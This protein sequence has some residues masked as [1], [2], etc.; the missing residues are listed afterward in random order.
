MPVT[1]SWDCSIVRVLGLWLDEETVAPG[2]GGP[3]RKAEET[4]SGQTAAEERGALTELA[5]LC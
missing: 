2:D 5:H 3:D 1:G 4:G